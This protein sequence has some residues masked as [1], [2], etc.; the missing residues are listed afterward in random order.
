MWYNF[1]NSENHK[2]SCFLQNKKAPPI[3]YFL[4]IIRCLFFVTFYLP[5]YN[6]TKNHF[7]QKNVPRWQ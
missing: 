2:N 6:K 4:M 1:N 3:V 5:Y 7:A